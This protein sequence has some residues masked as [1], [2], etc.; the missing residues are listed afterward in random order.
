MIKNVILLL[1]VLYSSKG[2][3]QTVY[4]YN[5]QQGNN[6]HSNSN[7]NSNN[8]NGGLGNSLS[9]EIN[10]PLFFNYSTI[11]DLF[12]PQVINNAFKLILTPRQHNIRV[13]AQV[14]FA[15]SKHNSMPSGILAL[16]LL[17]ST[18]SNVIASNESIALSGSPVLLFTQPTGS[19]TGPFHFTY[20]AI[21]NPIT[22]HVRPDSYNFTITFTMSQP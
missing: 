8:G 15:G 12:Q 19:G 7:G 10:N 2:V 22:K 4:T 13:Y 1:L 16:K 5:S 6:Y 3:A 20:N 17:N 11:D 21:L 9:V 18:S 14:N